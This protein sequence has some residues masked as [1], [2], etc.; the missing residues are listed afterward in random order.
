MLV[1]LNDFS[2][3]K[4]VAAIQ[5]GRCSTPRDGCRGVEKRPMSRG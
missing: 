5:A 3:A 4:G 2:A 1:V